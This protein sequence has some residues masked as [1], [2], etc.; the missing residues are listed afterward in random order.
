MGCQ[1]NI[2]EIIIEQEA[3]Y[4]LAV[5]DNQ[6][7]LHLAIQNYFFEAN[8]ANF[9]GYNIDFDETFDKCHGRV[10][11]RRCWVG[12]DAIPDLNG[13]QNWKN[14]QTIIMVEGELLMMKLLLNIVTI[15]VVQLKQLEIF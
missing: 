12:Y 10:E 5:K 4:L 8:Q 13:S 9:K 11:S 1:K 15:L 2:A 14:L 6:P 3:D 7:T